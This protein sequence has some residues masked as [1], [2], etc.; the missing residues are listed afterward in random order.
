MCP[1]PLAGSLS[2]ALWFGAFIDYPGKHCQIGRT[3]VFIVLPYILHRCCN[4]SIK[5]LILAVPIFFFDNFFSEAGCNTD[6][7]DECTLVI[8]MF[9]AGDGF[10]LYVIVNF[11]GLWC[12]YISSFVGNFFM[13]MNMDTCFSF[14]AGLHLHR[15]GSPTCMCSEFS[16]AAHEN[17]SP[18]TL[19]SFCSFLLLSSWPQRNG[20]YI[21]V[22]C[23]FQP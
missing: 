6:W 21:I 17:I 1:Y 13:E 8:Y 2:Q 5:R 22:S 15:P 7:P 9:F 10:S 16:H 11:S 3:L 14:S 20:M 19:G 23:L 18:C 4:T 12:F